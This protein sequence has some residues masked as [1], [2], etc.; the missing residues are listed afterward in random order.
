MFTQWYKHRTH[1]E[2]YAYLYYWNLNQNYN[3]IPHFVEKNQNNNQNLW[4]IKTK[5]MVF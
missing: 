3:K 2:V 5:S 4:S 1:V